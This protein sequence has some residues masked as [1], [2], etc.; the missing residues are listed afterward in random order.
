MDSIKLN[1]G[2][3]ELVAERGVNLRAALL[4]GGCSPHN[5]GASLVNCRGLGTCGTCAVEIVGPVSPPTRLEEARLRF[6]PHQGG[7][8]RLRLAC[9]V[10]ALGDLQITKRAGFWGQ[11]A[12]RVWGIER[13]E[14]RGS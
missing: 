5:D 10:E 3:R 2:D 11:G 1:V 4:S 12:A 7:P 13:E 9:Q 8:G 14:R 6:P